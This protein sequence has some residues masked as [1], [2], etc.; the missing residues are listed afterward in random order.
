MLTLFQVP[1]TAQSASPKWSTCE[2][3][4]R[5]NGKAILCRVLAFADVH[6]RKMHG[7]TRYQSTSPWRLCTT[8][9]AEVAQGSVAFF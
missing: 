5:A 2:S 9:S 4:A 8:Q 1:Q 6:S 3:A 7:R